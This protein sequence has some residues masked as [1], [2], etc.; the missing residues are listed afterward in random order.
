MDNKSSL[1]NVIV[2][3]LFIYLITFLFFML[4]FSQNRWADDALI[5]VF[6]TVAFCM[7]G[8]LIP[9]AITNNYKK[10]YKMWLIII[11]SV[12]LVLSILLSILSYNYFNELTRLVKV[13]VFLGSFLAVNYLVCD[14][15]NKNFKFYNFKIDISYFKLVLITACAMLAI[16]FIFDAYILSV[17]WYGVIIGCG[18]LVGM[19]LFIGLA[20]YRDIKA[21]LVFDLILFVFPL[22]IVGARAYY[23]LFSLDKFDWTFYEIIAV[24][25]GGLAIYGGIIGGVIG[26]VICCLIKKQNIVKIMELACPC[27]IIG[28]AIGRWGNFVNQEAFGTLVTNKALKWFPFA[29]FIESNGAWHL[30]TFFYESVL[31]LIGCFLLIYLIRKFKIVGIGIAGYMIWYGLERVI[32]EGFRTDSLYIGSTNIRVS[33]LLSAILVL[34]GIIYLTVLIVLKHVKHN[35]NEKDNQV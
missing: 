30:A 17:S 22:S 16:L 13:L 11:A 33:Q 26:I 3:I 31:S 15:D 12:G 35:N 4:V 27:L 6:T 14:Y 28:Q 2:K 21:D 20:E 5:N 32:I 18:F 19:A 9:F 24:W 34:V 29:V 23:I 10:D 8:G 1:K 25:N 7:I